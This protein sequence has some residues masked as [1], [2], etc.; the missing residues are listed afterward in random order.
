MSAN[1]SRKRKLKG[2]GCSERKSRA[3]SRGEEKANLYI[4]FLKHGEREAAVRLL[5]VYFKRVLNRDLH[6]LIILKPTTTVSTVRW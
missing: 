3:R 5:E 4:Y 2:K 1:F 6:E